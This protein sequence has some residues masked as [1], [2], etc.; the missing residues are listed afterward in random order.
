METQ[1]TSGKG[2]VT[3]LPLVAV[4]QPAGKTG[5]LVSSPPVFTVLNL[6]TVTL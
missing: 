2:L 3:L 6:R 5:C 4:K 1:W